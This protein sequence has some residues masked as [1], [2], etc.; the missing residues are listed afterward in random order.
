[1]FPVLTIGPL[2]LSMWR[3]LV[4][5]GVVLCWVLLL[6]RTRR[7]GYPT[8]PVLAF[9]VLELGVGTVGGH[10]LNW[11]I[12]TL[13]GTEGASLRGMTVIGSMISVLVFGAL[14]LERMVHARPLVF[15][16]AA[17]FTLPLAM[18][19]GRIG[20]LL[21]GCCF[22]KLA[23]AWAARWPFAAVTIHA[24]AF[25][26]LSM[27]SGSLKTVPGNPRL[28]NL[29]LFL[30]ANSLCALIAAEALYRRRERLAL[31]PGTVLAV[32][33]A[34]EVGGRFL[35]EFLRWD[36]SVA[37]TAFNPWQ[38]SLLAL[39]VAA[40]AFGYSTLRARQPQP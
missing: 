9:L 8:L 37:G 21:N 31:R 20:C 28:W 35:V 19:A 34:V 30:A 26:P 6:V 7:L 16:D 18:V 11:I 38:L 32:V 40:V 22:G 13:F 33:V 24:A 17:A 36:A 4:L 1:M 29:P 27:A 3:V 15:L 12:P 14:F 39:F 23:P 10:L 5:D 2:E 25:S